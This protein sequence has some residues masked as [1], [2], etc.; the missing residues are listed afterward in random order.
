MDLETQKRSV[1][2]WRDDS[3]YEPTLTQ[4]QSFGINF[5]N[6]FSGQATTGGRPGADDL[7]NP[8]QFHAEHELLLQY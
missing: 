4:C 1:V 3:C 7:R 6:P 2:L 5:F 8:Q